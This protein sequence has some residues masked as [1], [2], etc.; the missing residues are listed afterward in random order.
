MNR[1]LDAITDAG[2]SFEIPRLQAGLRH[3]Q[4][5]LARI[6]VSAPTTQRLQALLQQLLQLGARVSGGQD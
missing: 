5:S 4:E 1:V 3:D 6:H 2:G